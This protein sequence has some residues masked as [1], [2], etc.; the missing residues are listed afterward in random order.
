MT[1]MNQ[2]QD[3]M[4]AQTGQ[5]GELPTVES[6]QMAQPLPQEPTPVASPAVAPVE[7]VDPL[8]EQFRSVIAERGETGRLMGQTKEIDLNGQPVIL[9]H[10][11][12]K[13]AQ[14]VSSLAFQYGEGAPIFVNAEYTDH[15][16]KEVVSYP[17]EIAKRGIEYFE[18][19]EG[20]IELVTEAD[21]FLSKYLK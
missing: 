14:K 3:V 6:P 1:E 10:P 12:I 15:L 7:E 8:L 5:I 2:T 13:K 11:G 18:E 4:A 16:I 21:E 17:E 20:M 19:H 9:T